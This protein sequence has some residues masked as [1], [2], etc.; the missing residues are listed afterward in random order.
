MAADITQ[1]EPKCPREASDTIFGDSWFDRSVEGRGGAFK[2]YIKWAV[3][4]KKVAR[5]AVSSASGDEALTAR[6]P[7]PASRAWR[8]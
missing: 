3:G 7:S 5:E 8:R 1:F 4:A 2:C 6:D